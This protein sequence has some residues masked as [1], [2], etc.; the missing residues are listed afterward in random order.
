MAEKYE[1]YCPTCGKY[2]YGYISEFTPR[3]CNQCLNE[4][5][6]NKN[7]EVKLIWE[8]CC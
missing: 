3:K 5:F 6:V 7:G 2:H 8:R 4:F 1:W